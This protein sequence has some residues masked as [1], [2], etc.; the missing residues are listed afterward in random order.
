MVKLFERRLAKGVKSPPNCPE[1]S[2]EGRQKLEGYLSR[3][4]LEG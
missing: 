1:L 3:F 2:A 4:E